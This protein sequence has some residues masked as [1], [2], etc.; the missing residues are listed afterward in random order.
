MAERNTMKV[1]YGLPYRGSK[2]AI[3]D[4]IIEVLPDAENFYDFFAGGGAITHCAMLSGRWQN[5]YA[6]DIQNTMQ[7]FMD[8]VQGKYRN[9]RRWIS[10]EQFFAEKDTNPYVRWIWSFGNNGSS[11]IFGKD[12][13]PI[14][15]AAHEYLMANGYDGTTQTRIRLITAFKYEMKMQG[16]FELQQLEQLERLQQLEVTA[17][18]YRDVAIKPNSVIYCDIP[19][20]QKK[21]SKEKYYGLTF[22]TQA[23]YEWA[24]GIDH[25]V[26][27]S[28]CFCADPDF[29]EVWSAA[30]QCTMNNKGAHGKKAIVERLY[31][32]GTGERN[33]TDL[34]DYSRSSRIDVVLDCRDEVNNKGGK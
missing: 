7:L 2:K 20:N 29:T 15:K 9:E 25:P 26:Y 12:V 6:N 24:K 23:F 16:R 28:S 3:A 10:R 27:F 22:D 31:W 19:Y 34:F 18:D 17:L 5:I 11:Y 13:E 14:K 8:A 32:N 30:K 4:K 33:R 21:A 1:K